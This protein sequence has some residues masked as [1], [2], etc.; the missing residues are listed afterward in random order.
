[1]AL[2]K[3]IQDISDAAEAAAVESGLKQGDKPMQ[4]V[5]NAAVEPAPKVEQTDYKERYARYKASTDET[6]ADLRATLAETQAT[7][8]QVQRQN[9]ELLTKLS[10]PEPV[11][12]TVDPFKQWF[13][14]LPQQIK[15]DYEEN[16]LR[17]QYTI[18][19]SMQQKP[20][21]D[22]GLKQLEDRVNRVD[23]FREK[24]EVE[25]YEEA[26][27]K[28]FPDD[29]WIT[30]THGKEWSDFCAKRVS[31]VDT[32]TYG[33]IVKQGSDSHSAKS[34]IWVLKQFEQYKSTLVAKKPKNNLD[35][36]LTPE[37]SGGGDPIAAINAQTETFTVSQVNKFFKDAA[38][39]NKYTAEEAT[40]IEKKIIAAQA[41][42][43]IIQG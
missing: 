17:D 24:T 22:S 21:P 2:P 18:Q 43:K 11:V 19:T 5:E 4:S 30:M 37:G 1:M 20:E 3:K 7:M 33:E 14:K 27:D 29:A 23:Q 41:A 31:D 16:Y 39:T 40:A 34:V 15:D 8:A 10:K 42:G 12:E 25:L 35:E 13:D 9:Q 36:Q 38:T 26:M 6:I 28:A 32:R